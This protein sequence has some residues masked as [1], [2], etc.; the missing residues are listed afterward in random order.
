MD[1]EKIF[2]A[3]LEQLPEGIIVTDESGIIFFVNA[4]AAQ[5]RGISK[6]EI[7]GRNILHCHSESSREKVKRA[8][9]YLKNDN[10][11]AFKRMVVNE[12][13]GKVYENVYSPVR[14]EGKY[15]GSVVLS[16]DTTENRKFLSGK[17]I[18]AK[19]YPAKEEVITLPKTI[20]R[21]IL[22]LLNMKRPKG[23]LFNTST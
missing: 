18:F 4:T 11:R 21:D 15:L 23:N 7:M 6:K 20:R 22:K 14:A 8:L 3:V 5:V 2:N 10:T 16:R 1:T 19:A 13:T 12:A 17:S 9:A